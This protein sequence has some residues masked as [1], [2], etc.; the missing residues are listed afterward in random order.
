MT[1]SYY[2]TE[3]KVYRL[4]QPG[5]LLFVFNCTGRL[6]RIEHPSGAFATMEYNGLTR[7]ALT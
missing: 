1:L 4:S 5:G 3:G 6:D 7:M 2:P